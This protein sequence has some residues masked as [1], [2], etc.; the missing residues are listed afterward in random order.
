MS[1]MWYERETFYNRSEISLETTTM[2]SLVGWLRQLYQRLLCLSPLLVFHSLWI[3]WN[4]SSILM[5]LTVW[6][7]FFKLRWMG[8]KQWW[9]YGWKLPFLTD[10]FFFQKQEIESLMTEKRGV[11]IAKAD[12]EAKVNLCIVLNLCFLVIFKMS[13]EIIAVTY[14]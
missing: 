11:V 4:M 6:L 1:V 14:K 8:L 12:L 2:K 9:C 3:W 5:K 7:I 10:F 13:K